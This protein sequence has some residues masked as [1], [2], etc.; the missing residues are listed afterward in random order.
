MKTAIITVAIAIA[1]ALIARGIMGALVAFEN[2]VAV[3]Q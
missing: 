2:V 3:I 1:A